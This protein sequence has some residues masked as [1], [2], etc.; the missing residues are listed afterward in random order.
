MA[1]EEMKHNDFG[2]GETEEFFEIDFESARPITVEEDK[3]QRIR[4]ELLSLE[5]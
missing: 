4:Q 1:S 5:W 2:T 3:N